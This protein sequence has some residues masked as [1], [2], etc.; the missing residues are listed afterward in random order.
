M[1]VYRSLSVL[2]FLIAIFITSCSVHDEDVS[3]TAHPAELQL[4]SMLS[5]QR[6]QAITQDSLGY[7]W[8]GTYRGLNRYNGNEMR[9]YF[10]DDSPY[11]IPDNQ[12]WGLYVD[13]SGKMWVS[14]K[15]GVAYYTENDDFKN[16]KVPEASEHLSLEFAQNRA[17][18]LF[19]LQPDR[20]LRYDSVAEEFVPV[21]VDI[22]NSTYLNNKV[23]VSSDDN[24]WIVNR[25]HV[26]CYNAYTFKCQDEIEYTD[27]DVYSSCLVG[28][29]LWL[30]HQDQIKVYDVVRHRW[31]DTPHAFLSHPQFSN[32]FVECMQPLPQGYMLIGTR[33]GL[34]Y[35]HIASDVLIHQSEADFPFEA[36]GFV[37]NQVLCDDKSNVWLCSESQGF[38]VRTQ[39]RR[40]FNSNNYLR[41]EFS[42]IPVA[43]VDLAEDSIL[44]IA[45]QQR[46]LYSYSLK[47]H[48]IQR[49][50]YDD[51]D[52]SLRDK[53]VRAYAVYFDSRGDLWLACLPFGVL[54][55]RPHGKT[56]SLVRAYDLN[57]PISI[58]EDSHGTI[59]VG[60][61][62]NSYYSLRPGD[63]VF[64]EHY[65]LANIQSYTSC[66]LSLS[67]GRLAALTKGQGLRFVDSDQMA[68]QPP[69]FT[70]SMLNEC[71]SRSTF[72][73]SA[74]FQDSKGNLWIGTV[75]N[76]LLHYDMQSGQLSSVSG[77][78]CNDISSIE[79]D[80]EGNLWIS[81]QYGLGCL[82]AETN[83]FVNYYEE[84]GIGGN[85]FYD[86][87]S[88]SLPD[89]TLVFGGAHGL[90]V[91]N[92]A[93]LQ[94]DFQ[95][96]LYFEN[97]K[98]D[99]E[100]VRPRRSASLAC[101]INS[102]PQVNLSYDQTNFSIS[103]A[104]LDFSGSERFLYQY[105]LDG[106][107]KQWVD[108]S[109]PHEAYF[110]N[111]TP[112]HYTFN[113]RATSKDQQR[114]IAERSLPIVIYP[115]PWATWWAWL[116]YAIVVLAVLL[117][118]VRLIRR[119]RAE[120]KNRLLTER[121][122][123]HERR[124]NRMNMNFF[125]NVSHEFRTP[126][127]I[128]SAPITQLAADPDLSSETRSLLCIVQRSVD[129]ML[130]L[131][132]QMM[133]FHKLEDDALRLEVRRQDVIQ[134]LRQTAELFHLQASEKKIQ[135]NT[136]G[137]ED[138]YL[139]WIDRDKVEKIIYNLL[140]NALKYTPAGGRVDLTFDATP[141]QVRISVSDTGQGVP[142]DQMDKIFERYY[143]LRRQEQGQFNWGT[144]I[145]LYYAQKL[146]HLHHGNISVENR[147]YGPG[148]IFT[149]SLPAADS[150]YSENE[151][152]TLLATQS[153]L[154]PL[155]RPQQ[156]DSLSP[157]DVAEPENPALPTVLV[158]DDDVEIVH[159]VK[160]LLHSRY[161]VMSR[162]DA[163][164]GIDLIRQKAPDIIL[165]DVMMPG[166]DGFEFCEIVKNDLQI[167]H[168]PIVLL[169]AKTTTSDM[170]QGLGTG[171]DA[172][173]TKPFDPSYLLALIDSIL[174]NRE[175]TRNLLSANTQT[176]ALDA[177]VLSPQDKVFMTELYKIMENELS[178]PDLDVSHMTEFL[179][180]SRSKL[181]YKIKGL[182]GENPSV[183]FR[184]YKL[185]R[186]AE[187]I[188]EGRYNISEISLMTGFSTLSHFSTSFKRQ[189]GV[190]PSEY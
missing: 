104:V 177:D 114:V 9:Q 100:L 113:V 28:D 162:F 171:A 184:K 183:F 101:E 19:L 21:I 26:T 112:G 117:Y 107:N 95:P 179:H 88:C 93:D 56:L 73:P 41:A 149:V 17:G 16:V 115:A 6:I 1:K 13:R 163:D 111:L 151:K 150:A 140:G 120:R 134:L 29:E 38:D 42:G 187:M 172:Y 180:V 186:A 94:D 159:Y 87:S 46:G 5:N 67:D 141:Q 65:I 61:Y 166:R 62:G 89:G 161:Q 59:W 50:N 173:V 182:T 33:K 153:V 176:E 49:Y 64:A 39:S 97:L 74:L 189:F 109:S 160:T 8:L 47:T 178:N 58:A 164:S 148:S 124:I 125:A 145:G 122:K 110:A 136:Y 118:I 170:V 32:A 146:A 63:T 75:S 105:C 11:S 36:P 99:N 174:K 156:P 154:Y 84:D 7:V 82:N 129:R 108:A 157:T 139:L 181:Y 51:I 147:N 14:T 137:L 83:E 10:C 60:S 90:T 79:V 4:S 66:L 45:T 40:R 142:E 175:K 135:L 35:Y 37:V 132:N 77:A 121:E 80:H 43:S 130:R 168:I 52:S 86:R 78:P 53:Q 57:V 92:P 44:W 143:Q 18:D 48:E 55:L 167:C 128:I 85:E 131:V 96:R 23:Y 72:L 31:L 15:N 123:E 34:F 165:C 81:T 138:N 12:I 30:S 25:T 126:L 188:R 2:L 102:V 185:N 152:S 158:I 91:F 169:T 116:I 76:G 98:V 24:L 22:A 119:N 103:F 106:F 68:M 3:S 155:D 20:L 54:Q 71:V 69:V 133:D 190:A 127:T 27:W 144:G 70:D